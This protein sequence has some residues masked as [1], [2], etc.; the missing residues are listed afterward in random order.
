MFQRPTWLSVR[1]KTRSTLGEYRLT[2]LDRTVSI[3]PAGIHDEMK[4]MTVLL[5]FYKGRARTEKSHSALDVIKAT[6]KEFNRPHSMLYD[7]YET[8]NQINQ[9][10]D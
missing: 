1:Q 9:Q 4:N 6:P 10:K 5:S 3:A 8:N 2:H 7:I